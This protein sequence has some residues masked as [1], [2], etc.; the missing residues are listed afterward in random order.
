MKI[1]FTTS[2]DTLDAPL[3]QRFGRSPKFLIYDLDANTFGML[4]NEQNLQAVQGAGI[5]S[6]QHVI[7]SGAE[8]LVTGHLGPKA[9]KVVFAAG[10]QVYQ[11]DAP[12]VSE[13]LAL[14]RSKALK[15]VREADVEGHWA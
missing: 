11:S 13:A 14:Y 3:D 12:T 5:Q 9:A 4:D 8:A 10:I 1:A 15:H 2:G 6:A 7:A